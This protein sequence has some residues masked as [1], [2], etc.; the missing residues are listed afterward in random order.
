MATEVAPAELAA[1]LDYAERP[2][3]NDWSLRAAL[4][5]YA[6]PQPQRASDLIEVMRRAE[7]GLRSRLKD[8]ERNGEAYWAAVTAAEDEDSR[9]GADGNEQTGATDETAVALLRLMVEIDRLGDVLAGWAVERSGDR[10]D[11]A[12]DGMIAAG[13]RRLDELGIPHE[14]RPRPTGVGE[15]PPSRR[16]S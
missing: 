15:R 1:L 4:T 5:R 9:G 16:R 13:A 8:V 7:F 10:P 12:I 2:R 3:T 14:E 6:Q 11:A